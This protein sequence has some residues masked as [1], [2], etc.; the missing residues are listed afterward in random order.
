MDEVL[1]KELEDHSEILYFHF[2]VKNHFLKLETFIQ[3]ADS[4]R[5]VVTSLNETFFQKSLQY[6]LV[7]LPPEEG[8]F[9]TRLAVWVGAVPA[10]AFAFANT[11]VGAAYIEGLTGRPPIE[12]AKEFGEMSGDAVKVF[13]ETLNSKEKP[14][15]EP[16]CHPAAKIVVA[17]T[18]GVLESDSEKLKKLGMENGPL[19]GA[20]DARAEFYAACIN[21]KDVN[22][23]GFLPDNDFPIPRS[24]FA[25][26]AQKPP[27]KGAE[28]EPPEWIVSIEDI[29]VTSPN[30]DK[31]DQHVRNWKGK[32]QSHRDCYFV[33]DD[34]QFWYLVRTKN[35]HVDVLDNLKVQWACQII[36]GR[37]KNRRVIRVLEYNGNN[38]AEPLPPDALDAILGRHNAATGGR[39]EPSLF[40]RLG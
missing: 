16:S 14:P 38:L 25:E 20:M 17:M 3:T 13:Y 22:R 23:V 12:W 40:D 15:G 19:V 18:K 30:W 37:A 26:R 10:A 31:D 8:S 6:E 5:K 27:R 39:E 24:S 29:Y 11:D 1:Y 32:D 21:D 4:A 9:L 2:D 33:I 28:E 36:N 7:V 34:A 35:L